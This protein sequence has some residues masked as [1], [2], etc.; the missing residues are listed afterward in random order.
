MFTCIVKTIY[1]EKS[2]QRAIG[3]EG[4]D[5]IDAHSR[6][7]ENLIVGAIRDPLYTWWGYDT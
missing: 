7:K 5:L 4:V 6:D 3:M 1:L 2:E